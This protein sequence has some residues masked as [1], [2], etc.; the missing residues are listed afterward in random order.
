MAELL[1]RNEKAKKIGEKLQIV[2]RQPKNL[3]RIVSGTNKGGGSG[4]PPND[5][6]CHKCKKCRVSCPILKEGKQF[7]S[8]NT[9]KI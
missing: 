3:Q 9:R 5:A 4:L 1:A 8:T 7:M 2:T 6:D